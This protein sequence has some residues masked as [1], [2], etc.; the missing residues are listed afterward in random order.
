MY[1]PFF[2]ESADAVQSGIRPT[3]ENLWQKAKVTPSMV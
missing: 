2:K 1:A 3:D